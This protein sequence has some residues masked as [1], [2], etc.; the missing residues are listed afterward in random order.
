[1]PMS[2]HLFMGELVRI[3]ALSD[4]L[5]EH[6][7]CSLYSNAVSDGRT[8]HAQS[9]LGQLSMLY[10]KQGRQRECLRLCIRLVR[11]DLSAYRIGHLAYALERRGWRFFARHFFSRVLELPELVDAPV[12][13]HEHARVALARLKES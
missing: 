9:C 2:D 3:H 7:L 10:A 5:A 1:M 4:D 13:W 11:E 8:Q 12:R 6:A